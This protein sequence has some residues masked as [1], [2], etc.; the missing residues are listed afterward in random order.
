MYNYVKNIYVHIDGTSIIF[1]VRKGVPC[2]M[3]NIDCGYTP[4]HKIGK[5]DHMYRLPPHTQHNLIYLYI[6]SLTSSSNT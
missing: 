6:D 1:N 4:K 2:Y 3:F 5:C